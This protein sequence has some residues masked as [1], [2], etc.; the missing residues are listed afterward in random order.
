M[1]LTAKRIKQSPASDLA[2]L[3]NGQYSGDVKALLDQVA[4][5]LLK[6]TLATL[7][8]MHRSDDSVLL[9]SRDT[10]EALACSLAAVLLAD[11]GRVSAPRPNSPSLPVW[12]WEPEEV[13]K[14][15]GMSK[16][17]LYR[18]DHTKF[19]SVIPPGMQNGRA[20]PA[21]QFVGDV[22]HYLPK[23][24]SVLNRKS[25][26]QVNT[27]LVSQQ[28]ALNELSPAE[29]L[30]GLPFEDRGALGAPQ[31]RM[32]SLPSEIRLEKVLALAKLEVADPV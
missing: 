21:W 2:A 27:F 23:V 19:Y 20:Y 14:H 8:K 28:D 25:R 6:R 9:K 11:S 26:L 24:L 17:T 1:Q 3:M 18:G 30:A 12:K 4:V 10:R 5:D 31:A 32:L 16:S 22:P 15:T 7:R 13:L 29:V